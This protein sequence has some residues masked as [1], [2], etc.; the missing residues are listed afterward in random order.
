MDYDK[1]VLT[2]KGWVVFEKI[3]MPYFQRIPNFLIRMKLASCL[4]SRESFQ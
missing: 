1:K 4:L 3:T 2:Y